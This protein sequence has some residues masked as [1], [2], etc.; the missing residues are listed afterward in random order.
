[1]IWNFRE[2]L[3][4]CLHDFHVINCQGLQQRHKL[5][6]IVPLLHFFGNELVQL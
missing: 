2:P 4:H 6:A 5:A 3:Q 1:L